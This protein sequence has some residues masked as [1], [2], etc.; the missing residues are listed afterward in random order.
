[1]QRPGS[2][3]G[4]VWH[5]IQ[6]SGLGRLSPFN[7]ARRPE[8]EPAALSPE[9]LAA[10]S[11]AGNLEAFESLV[12]QHQDRVF[13]F[14][15][16][17]VGNSHDAEDLA[18]ETFLRVYQGLGRYNPSLSFATWLFTIARRVGA[19]H[20]RRAAR[21]FHPEPADPAD[22]NDP[23]EVL[24]RKDE[25]RSLWRLARNLKPNQFQALW[26]RYAEGFSVA[27][28][29]RIMRLTCVHVKVLLHRARAQLAKQLEPS[30]CLGQAGPEANTPLEP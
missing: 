30:D 19:S 11:Q 15:F 9:R 24:A 4:H 10:E 14:L 17:M 5:S 8:A 21:S 12:E 23:A 16:R 2:A 29:A 7:A 18:Q 13:N 20:F 25:Q 1:M 27:E 26:L 6:E 3:I 28:V 22:C